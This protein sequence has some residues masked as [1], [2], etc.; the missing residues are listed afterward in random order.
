MHIEQSSI[1][2][3]HIALVA[4]SSIGMFPKGLFFEEERVS[5]N[6]PYSS[7]DKVKPAPLLTRY[8][9]YEGPGR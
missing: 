1:L 2:D 9:S 5:D 8:R 6:G 4:R 3:R 7:F